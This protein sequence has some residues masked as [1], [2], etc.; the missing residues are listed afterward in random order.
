MGSGSVARP[1]RGDYA[2]EP[3]LCGPRARWSI[4]RPVCVAIGAS[5]DDDRVLSARVDLDHG[6]PCGDA[7]N[8]CEP[9][10]V[11]AFSEYD[12]AQCDARGVI[13]DGADQRNVGASSC[14]SDGLIQTLPAGKFLIVRSADR[15]TGPGEAG[16]AND[17]IEIQAPD[18]TN[19][20]V[21]Q[22]ARARTPIGAMRR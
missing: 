6:S 4:G 1:A 10:I 14:R 11:D 18:D 21:G 8:G 20:E 12:V 7:C 3:P 22:L 9:T 19:V 2:R 15:F 17:K 16:R 5:N 13:A